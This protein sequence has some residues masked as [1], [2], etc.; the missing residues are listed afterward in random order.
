M[1]NLP[2]YENEKKCLYFYG[3]F[4]S[5][6][7]NCLTLMVLKQK[8]KFFLIFC[9]K[10]F[11]TL[12]SNRTLLFLACCNR[13]LNGMDL[14]MRQQTPLKSHVTKGVTQYR[15]LPPHVYESQAE[16]TYLR[17]QPPPPKKK[18]KKKR[19]SIVSISSENTV[20]Q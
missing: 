4:S 13:W 19:K 3:I 9:D 20:C 8:I 18:K 11:M 6:R 15:Y 1:S 12:T 7:K 10:R 2:S 16:Q 17:E 5:L 14:Q